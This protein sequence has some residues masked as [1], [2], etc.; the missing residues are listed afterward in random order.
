[1]NPDAYCACETVDCTECRCRCHGRL[2]AD[3]LYPWTDAATW[4]ADGDAVDAPLDGY[5]ASRTLDDSE[6]MSEERAAWYAN[7]S[8]P[9]DAPSYVVDPLELDETDYVV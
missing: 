1:M 8:R 3:E 5:A 2:T 7:W 6:E 4:T 9:D